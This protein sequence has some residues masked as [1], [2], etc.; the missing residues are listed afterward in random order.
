MDDGTQHKW[1]FLWTDDDK[2]PERESK[3]QVFQT[4]TLLEA[5]DEM[6][7]WLKEYCAATEPVVDCEARA[8]HLIDDYTGDDHATFFPRLDTLD[9]PISEYVQ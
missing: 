5:C 1:S 9:H 8:E 2:Y 3:S 6:V 4:P 7:L